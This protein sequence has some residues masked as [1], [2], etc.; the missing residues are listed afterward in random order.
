MS[1]TTAY[2][3]CVALGAVS[4][5]AIRR[6]EASR[7]G[8]T[9][10]P[11]YRFVG[12]GCLVGAVVGAKLGMLMYLPLNDMSLLWSEAT[13][14]R[15]DGKTVVGA[16][17]GGYA[18]GELTKKL[19]GVR[20]STGDALAVALPAGQAIGRLGCFFAGCCYGTPCDLPWAV[21]GHGALRHPVPL[22]EAV[23]DLALAVTLFAIRKT[24][25]PPGRLF[26]YYLIGYGVI[27][28]G[29]ETLRGEPQRSLG[30]LSATQ[31]VCLVAIG[32]L[33]ISLQRRGP[34]P[35]LDPAPQHPELE[36]KR[37]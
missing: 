17:A 27:R 6:W 29:L 24:P 18:A 11:G 2:G 16:L 22:Y 32:V 12:A 36:T 3:V 23:L 31:W 7:L 37:V 33:A 5:L 19:A 30:P 28:F 20:F 26:R 34:E 10:D 21:H 1:P 9:A 35:M 8:Y 14:L 13:S 15:F 25:R 4:A